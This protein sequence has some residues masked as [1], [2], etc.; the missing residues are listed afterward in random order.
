M[1]AHAEHVIC[2]VTRLYNKEWRQIKYYKNC[3]MWRD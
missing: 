3:P 1:F 2:K